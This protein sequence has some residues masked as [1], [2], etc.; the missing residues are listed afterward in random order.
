MTD[1][2]KRAGSD[3]ASPVTKI[4]ING[5]VM[6]IPAGS[7]LE[8]KGDTLF[9]SGKPVKTKLSGV[10]ELRITGDVKRVSSDMNVTIDGDANG[11]VSAVGKVVCQTINGPATAAKIV[12]HG[13]VNGPVRAGKIES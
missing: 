11:P 13:N 7:E 5:F 12:C 3:S 4:D 9:V 8:L 10:V 1:K 2:P 6:H